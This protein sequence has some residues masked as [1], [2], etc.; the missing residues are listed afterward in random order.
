[1]AEF[2]ATIVGHVRDEV[3]RR[4]R[5]K[6]VAALRDRPFFHVSSRGFAAAL[7]G[8]SRRLKVLFGKISIP[9]RLRATMPVTGP[10]PFQ[11]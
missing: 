5:E 6:P 3:E 2:L 11:C 1:M 4:R 9:W 7:T 8:K 10:A